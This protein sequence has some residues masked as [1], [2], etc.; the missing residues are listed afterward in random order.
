MAIPVG[1]HWEM[2]DNSGNLAG[3][4]GLSATHMTFDLFVD[5]EAGDAIAAM[6]FGIAGGNV[7][8]STDGVFH[9][10]P[11]P[12]TDNL[13]GN[14][15]FAGFV[16]NL[17]YGTAVTSNGNSVNTVAYVRGNPLVGAWF[18]G[19][20]MSSTGPS[21]WAARVTVSN[22]AEFGG[23]LTTFL[24][25]QIFV[26]GDGPNGPFG[27]STPDIPLGVVNLPNAKIPTPGALA[28]FGLAGAAAIRRR[29]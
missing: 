14:I 3:T 15:A 25:G 20:N 13:Q 9:F 23:G 29:R 17:E 18:R 10:A 2:V 4:T 21:V 24:G 22:N 6:D 1:A 19:D 5:L 28:L 11:A 26:S 7:G 27:Q 16:P 8:L 12:G